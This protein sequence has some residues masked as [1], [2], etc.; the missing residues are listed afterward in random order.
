MVVAL[1]EFE[2]IVKPELPRLTQLNEVRG[3][4]TLAIAPEFRDRFWW[5]SHAAAL[6]GKAFTSMAAV[7]GLVAIFPELEQRFLA[8]VETER[9]LRSRPTPQV[10]SLAGWLQRRRGAFEQGRLKAAAADDV[11][12]SELFVKREYEISFRAPA[13]IVIDVSAELREGELPALRL[14]SGRTLRFEPVAHA[15]DR[16]VVTLDEEALAAE[17]VWIVVPL[18]D[19][20]AEETLP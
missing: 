2:Q 15:L 5:Y 14:A 3:A 1:E 13:T 8:L 11:Q 10:V 9:A 6:P 19:G 16:F 4:I 7:A 18:S 20:I 17:R 12:G